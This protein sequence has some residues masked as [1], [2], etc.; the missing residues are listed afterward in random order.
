MKAWEIKPG[1]VYD[2][3]NG[4]HRAIS[5]QRQAQWVLVSY[6][7]LGAGIDGGEVWI[8]QRILPVEKIY[9]TKRVDTE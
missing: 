9:C 4:V 3:G 1:S 6:E 7:Y 2:A 8:R 5:I